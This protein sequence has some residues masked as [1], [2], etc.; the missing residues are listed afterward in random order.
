MRPLAS[1]NPGSSPNHDIAEC[2]VSDL[3]YLIGFR[4]VQNLSPPQLINGIARGTLPLVAQVGR[5]SAHA[6]TPTTPS[7]RDPPHLKKRKTPGHGE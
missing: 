4:N 2:G 7:P 3:E 6:D 1:S 5:L